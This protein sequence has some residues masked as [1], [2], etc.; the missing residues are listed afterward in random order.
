VPR[1]LGT[2][3]LKVSANACG[4]FTIGFVEDLFATIIGDP[5]GNWVLP[6]PQPL[7][8]TI[9][10]N[11][12]PQQLLSCIPSHCN[13]D[14]RIARDRLDPTIRRT[15]F[16]MAMTF[17][18]P[19]TGMTAANFE[20]TVVPFDSEDFVPTIIAVTPNGADPKITTVTFL[21]RIQEARW[22]CVRHIESNRQCCIAS[23]PGDA[24]N[25]RMRRLDDVFEV[26]DNLQ[27]D[28]IPAL[29][30]EKCDID[31]SVRCAPADLL[32]LVD[33]LNDEGL[34]CDPFP[35]FPTTLPV[36]PSDV[37]PP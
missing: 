31:R 3:N 28:A 27:G 30:I 19:T 10:I 2:L 18:K 24:D 23:L 17:R 35:C 15:A 25:D 11:D 1:Y 36:C 22:T 14:A 32:M 34:I 20:I 5:S 26:F 16:Q 6:F 7:V 12:C 13:I 8:L 9:P 4:T 33:L 37:P 29:T 21:P